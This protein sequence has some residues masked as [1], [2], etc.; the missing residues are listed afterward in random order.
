MEE[1]KKTGAKKTP[2]KKTN[3]VKEKAKI[4]ENKSETCNGFTPEQM[5]QMQQMM[6]M[7]FQT[8]MQNVLP[9][10]EEKAEETKKKLE[11]SKSKQNIRKTKS[12]LRKERGDEEV[13]VRSVSGTVCFKSPKSG[14]TYNFLE[15][16]DEEW[17]TIDEVLQ[18]ETASKKYL[19]SPWLVVE[20]TEV[21]EILG[22]DKI[23]ESVDILNNIDE[24]LELT[25][26]EIEELLNNTTQD[27]RNTFGGVVMNKIK[28]E[29]LRDSV[30]I[31]EL[32]RI[33]NIDFD[34]Y[35]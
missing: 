10:E 18:M 28:D 3:T 15:N 5:A 29:E 4:E 2:P 19:H 30:L 23:A 6:G 34:L 31:R 20:D 35:K 12:Y 24:I 11:K 33:L 13:L 21:N 27:Y 17:L 25:V 32:G 1:N 7:M 9:K 16:G 14:I 26:G 22:I 8:M